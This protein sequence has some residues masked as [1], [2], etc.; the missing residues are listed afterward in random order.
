MLPLPQLND[1]RTTSD[2]IADAL[3]EAI[4]TG[5]FDD[6]EEL[7]QVALAKHFGISRVP[8]REALRQ[9][10][11]E[12][13]VS[14]KAHQRT[15]VTGLT[16]DRVVEILEVRAV[17]EA[18]LLTKAV[19]ARTPKQLEHLRDLCRQMDEITDHQVWLR[20][21]RE[22]HQTLYTNSGRTFTLDLIDQ[23]SARVARYLQLW[24]DTGIE[25]TKEANAEH[26][27]IIDAMGDG[28]VRRARRELE[29]HIA[30]TT[31]RV[32][33]QFGDHAQTEEASHAS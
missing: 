2:Q 10:Q 5:E 31:E 20:K 14:A 16:V 22:F 8:I 25:R 4:L 24:S 3:R 27:A 7:N 26:W 33:K 6:G 28:D 29:T 18:H 9:L 13:L 17:L 15:V 19:K 32:I 30:H 1:R 11:A 12:G 21:N 23:L